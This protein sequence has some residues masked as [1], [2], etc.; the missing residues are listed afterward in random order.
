MYD[1]I[2][3]ERKE[4]TVGVYGAVRETVKSGNWT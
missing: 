1:I 3:D 4:K 2:T